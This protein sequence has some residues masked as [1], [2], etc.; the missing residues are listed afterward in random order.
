MLRGGCWPHRPEK[1]ALEKSCTK[2]FKK[3]SCPSACSAVFPYK[4]YAK[5]L[6]K[7]SGSSC[8]FQERSLHVAEIH[9]WMLASTVPQRGRSAPPRSHPGDGGGAK[10]LGAG[11]KK[12]RSACAL[13]VGMGTACSAL[14]GFALTGPAS[15]AGFARPRRWRLC[16][17]CPSVQSPPPGGA[18]RWQTRG[19]RAGWCWPACRLP[20]CCLR[21]AAAR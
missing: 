10:A 13:R 18:A 14:H 16:Q 21:W 11:M 17:G 15:A 4:T 2:L 20:A 7:G 1:H 6:C 5:W 19:F 3:R 12:T 9:A 8:F